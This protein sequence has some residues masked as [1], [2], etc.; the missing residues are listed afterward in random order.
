[1]KSEREFKRTFSESA[2][3]DAYKTIRNKI[4]KYDPDALIDSCFNYLREPVREQLEYVKRHPWLVLLLV[5][6]TLLDDEALT[7]A[8]RPPNRSEFIS[9]VNQVLAIEDRVRLPT[10]FE[11][12]TLFFRAIAYQQFLYQ[13]RASPIVVGRQILYF[14]AL[15]DDHYIAHTFASLT[16]MKLR[17]FLLLSQ[18]LVLAFA[19]PDNRRFIDASWFSTLGKSFSLGDIE[20]FLSLF[21]TS[22]SDIRE[23]LRALDVAIRKSGAQ[24]RNASEYFEQTPFLDWPLMRRFKVYEC[25]DVHLLDAC[26]GH[27]VYRRLKEHDAGRFMAHFGPIFEDYVRKAIV[28]MNLPFREE[29]EIA[30]STGK[31]EKPSVI[32]FV[33]YDGNS[34]IFIDAK[35]VEMHY[36]GKVTHSMAELSK[37]LDSSLLKAIKQANSTM[38]VLADLDAAQG[39]ERAPQGESDFLVVVTESELYI[40]NGMDLASA[41]GQETLNQILPTDPTKPAIQLD[42]MHFLTI[43]EFERLAAAVNSNQLGFAEALTRARE[44]N[45]YPETRRMVYDQHLS[46]WGVRKIAPNYVIQETTVNLNKLANMLRGV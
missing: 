18:A 25:V 34:R 16:G 4:R 44:E 21:A 43:Y 32:D 29:K 46:D 36:R 24:P 37:N 2:Y 6:W 38:Q 35:A 9:L 7:R 20:K 26:V 13:R 45:L 27:F 15:Q 40:S 22:R 12:L 5:K 23:S 41:V 31:K 33:V 14:A 8:R 1:M 28:H 42:H 3:Y 19:E 39:I 17:P 30:A 10:E 11:S